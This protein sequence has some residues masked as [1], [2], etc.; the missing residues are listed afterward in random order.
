MFSFQRRIVECNFSIWDLFSFHRR[1]W[2]TIF[3]MYSAFAHMWKVNLSGYGKYSFHVKPKECMFPHK[4]C[5]TFFV[6]K[7]Y[8]ENLLFREDLRNVFFSQKNC[9][10]T[11]FHIRSLW[12]ES[13]EKT[14]CPE[15][16][17][18]SYF[19]TDEPWKLNL[20]TCGKYS[21]NWTPVGYNFPT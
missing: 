4:S 16:I 21:A 12:T 11:F 19:A 8:L 7:R 20:L 14:T 1:L 17:S 15:T 6:H 5:G 2:E 13:P 18:E 9:G 10:M 3:K